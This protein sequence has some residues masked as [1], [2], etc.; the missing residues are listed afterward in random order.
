MCRL[1]PNGAARVILNFSSPE[2]FCVNDGINND[3]FPTT[4]SSTGEWLK[5][6][7]RCGKGALM[8]KID[9]AAAY[10]HIHVR[11][12]D[13][14]LQYFN[15]LGKDFVELMLVFG[16][17]SSAGIY[18]RLAKFVLILVLAY[19]RFPRKQV[20]QYLDDVCA[21]AAAGSQTLQKFQQ[22]YKAVASEIG[23][24]LA[25]TDDPDKAFAP[26]TNGVILGIHYDTV[27]WTWRIPQEKL[28]RVLLQIKAAVTADTLPQHEIWS[29]VGRLLHYAPLIPAAKFNINHLIKANNTSKLRR[30]PVEINRDMKRQLHFWW[31]I[32]RTT[33]GRCSIPAPAGPTPPWATTFYTD[34]AGGSSFSIGHGT[35]GVGPNMFFMVPWGRKINTGIRAAD[36]KRL[37]QKMS[38]LE[39]VG[40]LICVSSGHALCRG[41]H[42]RIWVDN[43][44]SVA[45]WKK[46][47]SSSCSLSTTLVAAIGRVAAALGCTVHIEKIT[48]RSDT[49]AMLSDDLSKGRFDRFTAQLPAEH[50][51]KPAWIPPA[52]LAWISNPVCSH[53]LGERILDDIRKRTYLL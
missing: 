16:A 2:G 8:L 44:G 15:W 27:Q 36:G 7:G 23:V 26:R 6:L 41:K 51:L 11:S 1:K 12:E 37:S 18:D 46:G 29:L 13:I 22:A 14:V 19:S 53:E 9:W 39:L 42:I 3:D 21:A 48:R 40:P 25:P 4:M 45:I 28:A 35:G 17:K 31:V 52:I 34:A 49:G 33:D 43:S 30:F 24:Q 20:C 5:V 32:L 50:N 47:Y 38:A 10:K